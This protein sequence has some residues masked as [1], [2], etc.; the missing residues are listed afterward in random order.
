MA[1]TIGQVE[2]GIILEDT[3]DLREMN[4]DF[5]R[6]LE[7]E[8]GSSAERIDRRP[9]PY[10]RIR[11]ERVP[12]PA[13]IAMFPD[14][15]SHATARTRLAADHRFRCMARLHG[16]GVPKPGWESDLADNADNSHANGG[17]SDRRVPN[18]TS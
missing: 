9:E 4:R 18:E 16:V 11:G 6:E 14:A 15:A 2:K 5:D 7:R 17:Q 8:S 13:F 12:N 3:A 10:L 1:R